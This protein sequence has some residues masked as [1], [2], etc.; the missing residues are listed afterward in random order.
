[1]CLSAGSLMNSNKYGTLPRDSVSPSH[2]EA[3]MINQNEVSAA[4]TGNNDSDV[5]GYENATNLQL[6][7][8]SF[9]ELQTMN[10]NEGFNPANSAL[11]TLAQP[12]RPNTKD[13]VSRYQRT[14][15]Q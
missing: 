13:V 12:I 5:V 8:S 15:M 9:R 11:N 10:F 4:D 1:M 6:A 7:V 2:E 3:M 14:A